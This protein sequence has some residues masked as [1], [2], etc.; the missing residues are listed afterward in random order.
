MALTTHM[1]K[2]NLD[3]V[4]HL[5]TSDDL[6][7]CEHYFEPETVL[8]RMQPEIAIFCNI[9][10][11]Q[12]VKRFAREIIIVLDFNGP[13]QFEGF[14]LDM[15]DSELAMR[16]G[17]ELESRCREMVEKLRHAD[18]LITV[19]ERQKYFWAAYCSLAG[20]SFADLNVLVCPASVEIPP[21]DRKTAEKMT[22][23][24]SGGFYPW[25]N[26]DRSLR[27]AARILQQIE[28]AKLHIFGGPHAGLPNE[29]AVMRLLEELQRY[30]C[31]EYHGFRP[32]EEL[33]ERQ[34][35]AWCALDLMERNIE[36]E[37]AI[38]GRT[39]V[40]LS[41]GT[42]VIH[43][44]YSTLSGLIEKY[45]AGWTISPSDPEALEAVFREI[46]KGG[47]ALV[48]QISANAR[49]L[50]AEEF[51][52]ESSMF[53]LVNLCGGDTPK[54]SGSKP[55][56]QPVGTP[57]GEPE[58]R[59]LAISPDSFA[60]LE[61]RVRNPL[62]ALQRRNRIAGFKTTGITFEGLADDLS[63]YSAV[64]IQRTVP[65]YVFA[66]LVNLGIP[67]LLDVDDNLLARASYRQGAG[68]ETPLIMGLRYATVITAPNPRLVR[69]L[70]KYSGLALAHKAFITPNALPYP[71]EIRPPS[72]PG[73]LLWIQSDV[74]ALTTSR[75][76]V[77]QAVEDFSR[78]H[79]LPVVLI[80][81][82]VLDRPQFKNQVIM[83]EIDF[84]ANLQLL[85]FAGTGI[86]IAP[87]ETAA[88]EETLDFVAGKS[89]LKMLLFD[90]YGHPGVYSDSPPYGDSPLRRGATLIGNSY[91]EWTEA[92]EYQFREGWLAMPDKAKL[93]RQ[94][95]HI[96]RVA[97]ESWGPAITAARLPK[98]VSGRLLYEAFRSSFEM[99]GHGG[100]TIGYVLANRD[101]ADQYID[102][103]HSAVDHFHEHGRREGRSLLHDADALDRFISKL[104][105][106]RVDLE[107]RLG[108]P[109]TRVGDVGMSFGGETH[110]L[111]QQLADMR[112]S[113]SWKITAPLRKVAKPF[114]ERNHR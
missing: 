3:K 109:A 70:E 23:V 83:G 106:E 22:V 16:N 76:G 40:F 56:R 35:T 102:E 112:N 108:N 41:T 65:E 47:R 77:A 29:Q 80:G 68:A 46:V 110:H 59:V 91:S 21:V 45:H 107:R 88:D 38:A 84:N 71:A 87:L 19:S 5:L 69:A 31:V 32:I 54:R 49:K 78:S 63:E 104:D 4:R 79:D 24:Y 105:D 111:R 66:A 27:A 60:L 90:G 86:G 53:A 101:V 72:A 36:R 20:F 93:I 92:L 26:P 82:N 34:S 57:K 52:P 12:S 96:D 99:R 55:L 114:M 74:A 50:A 7:C 2:S 81:R 67:Y 62:R 51:R 9:N 28:G 61:L 48:D 100:A 33:V 97:Q 73:Q 15:G 43:N 75:K 10:L 1:A 42:P 8:H 89:D 30:P 44:D 14:L 6:W 18:Y 13:I 95:R 64:L 37:L 113:L 98:A 103:T 39:V 85:E 25:Q 11:F 17:V 94:E 58:M